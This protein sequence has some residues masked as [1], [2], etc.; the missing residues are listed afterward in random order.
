MVK[1]Y[2]FEMLGLVNEDMDPA[3]LNITE[4]A[5][6]ML[7]APASFVSVLE[8]QKSRQYFSVCTGLPPEREV[9]RQ[10]PIEHSICRYVQEAERMVVIP[11]LL[12]DSRTMHNPLVHRYELRA[13][14]GAPIHTVS[15]KVA[16]A[17]CCMLGEI[18]HWTQGNRPVAIA[19]IGP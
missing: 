7:E 1:N 14:L 11:D 2:T 12:A 6:R 5:A 15:G 17:L 9:S 8:H 3:M 18:R 10:T 19:A 16:G 4:L 13:Y